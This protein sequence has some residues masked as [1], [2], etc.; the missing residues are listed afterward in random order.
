MMVRQLHAI[1]REYA[2]APWAE[3]E[4]FFDGA[5]NAKR[6]K[7]RGSVPVPVRLQWNGASNECLVTLRRL[8]DGKVAFAQVV[9]TNCVEVDGLEIGT[10]WEGTVSADGDRL[11]GRFRTE[12]V[13]PRLVRMSGTDN[14]R[15]IGGRRGLGGRRNTLFWGSTFP[16]TS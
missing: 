10:E 16:T 3:C 5:T 7:S 13:A 4:K 9:A 15:D 2:K 1:Q 11:V 14:C 6:L 12:D 8:P